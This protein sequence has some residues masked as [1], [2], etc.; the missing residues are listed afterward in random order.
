MALLDRRTPKILTVYS[1][2][3]GPSQPRI[4]N[5]ERQGDLHQSMVLPPSAQPVSTPASQR[6]TSDDSHRAENGKTSGGD[7]V[8][9]RPRAQEDDEEEGYEGADG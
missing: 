1:A 3:L 8:E 7:D 9:P 5:E 4:E 2:G 6:S